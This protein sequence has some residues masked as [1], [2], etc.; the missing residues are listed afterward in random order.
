MAALINCTHPKTAE[1]NSEHNSDLSQYF[2]TS[3]LIFLVLYLR[4]IVM[5]IVRTDNIA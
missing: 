5:N 3:L 1:K 4:K 2:F